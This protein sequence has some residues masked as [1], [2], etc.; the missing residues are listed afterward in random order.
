MTSASI[1]TRDHPRFVLPALPAHLVV[2]RGVQ[3]KL[4]GSEGC[5]VLVRAP[6]GYGKSSQVAHW[7]ATETRPVAWIELDAADDDPRELLA[8]LTGPLR[9]VAS[10]DVDT[11]VEPAF[12][13][14]HYASTVAAKL[15]RAVAVS[16]DPFV[17]VLDEVHLVRSAGAH[18]L[19]E[20]FAAHLP[21]TAT[22][23]LVG[24]GEPRT[25]LARL[26]GLA[27]VIDV[28]ST[29][30]ALDGDGVA[31]VLA[32]LAAPVN[33]E[34]VKAVLAET[35]GWP[36]GV[37]LAAMAMADP[38]SADS[39]QGYL[40]EEWLRDVSPDDIDFLLDVSG[41]DWL[42][43]P[44]CDHVL[45]RKD[46]GK[47]LDRLANQ[48]LLVLPLDR[49]GS[50]YRM[51][52][53]L[54]DVLESDAN[55]RDSDRVR[56]LHVR[57]SEWFER[58]DDI[59][60]AIQH[61]VA[62]D[63]LLRAERL[64][65]EHSGRYATGGRYTAVTRWVESFPPA[66]VLESPELCL[67]AAVSELGL[68]PGE[69]VLT[70]LRLGEEALRRNPE[71]E[72]GTTE[73]RIASFHGV[74][75]NEP[76][77]VTFP[78]VERGFHELPA[79][80]WRSSAALAFG[81]MSHG[82]GDEDAAIAAMR[83]CATEASTLGLVAIT[84]QLHAQ[85]A[86]I[87]F[88]NERWS[89]GVALARTARSILRDTDLESQPRLAAVFAASAVAEAYEGQ[90]D[91]A[92][93]DA[94]LARRHLPFVA[95]LAWWVNV[96]SRLLL[97]RAALLLADPGGARAALAEASAALDSQ[98]D[99]VRF[100]SIV[101]ELQQ[102]SRAA[103]A[104]LPLGVSSLTTAELRVL[105]FLPTN[106]SL[107]EIAQRLYVSRNTAKSQTASVYR[108]LGASSR[109]DAVELARAAGLLATPG[110]QNITDRR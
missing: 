7:A 75:S 36:V 1:G 64:V 46:S 2:R 5:V 98:P 97:G 4:A 58:I 47:V 6:G 32:A 73:L 68:E 105:H 25:A 108:K 33:D 21:A 57:S 70:W 20:A 52:R 107:G 31:T 78:M 94:A 87:E 54:R 26:R 85:L 72:T 86:A 90:V 95:N 106:L 83:V 89:S 15:G 30:L 38:R 9:S 8:T 66:Y 24:R 42:A 40:H 11:L 84:A 35:E 28:T 51:H 3:D 96:V 103:R 19:I 50:S 63:D 74:L 55:R 65:G 101:E 62:A 76:S 34:A 109:G 10:I 99:A 17:L 93:A 43:G 91:A 48:Q 60:R 18:E 67:A 37:R 49:R 29:D 27:R 14:Q 71:R 88:F 56:D 13:L 53:L 23:V 82:A 22:L 16:P 110:D 12:S 104:T 69:R 41:L 92:R 100:R 45:A 61:A 79:G 102:S 44:V 77:R 81:S 80:P 59:D 39:T